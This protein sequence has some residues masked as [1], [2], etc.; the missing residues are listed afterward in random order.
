MAVD[1]VLVKLINR[2]E[3]W[4]EQACVHYQMNSVA[5][6]QYLVTKKKN[7]QKTLNFVVVKIT[8][9]VKFKQLF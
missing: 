1:H 6:L 9:A 2:A 7:S 5:C 3:L 8:E 4:I